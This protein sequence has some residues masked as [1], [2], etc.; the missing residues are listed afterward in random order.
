MPGRAGGLTTTDLGRPRLTP[1]G[2]ATRQ[3]L[4][5]GAAAVLRDLGAAGTTLDDICARTSTSKSQIFHYFPGGEEELLLAVASREAHPATAR[6][7]R[8]SQ[9]Y[10]PSSAIAG[11]R[12]AR[13]EL[14]LEDSRYMRVRLDQRQPVDGQDRPADHHVHTVGF[15]QRLSCGNSR[16]RQRR[17]PPG[18]GGRRFRSETA[19][20]RRRDC[21]SALTYAP[22][23]DLRSPTR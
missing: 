10:S 21:P 20:L 22:F 5:E 3:R 18:G 23:Q 1:K 2:A 8:T 9:L 17:V 7:E 16:W 15:A 14:P 19:A 6:V 11:L 4:V 13:R 12:V